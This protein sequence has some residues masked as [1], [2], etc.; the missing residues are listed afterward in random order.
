MIFSHPKR[1]DLGILRLHSELYHLLS[2]QTG[3]VFSDSFDA[4]HPTY[5]D[6]GQRDLS[7]DRRERTPSCSYDPVHGSQSSVSRPSENTELKPDKPILRRHSSESY[8]GLEISSPSQFP[9]SNQL[10]NDK[11]IDVQS[12]LPP[13]A[14]SIGLITHQSNKNPVTDLPREISDLIL[15]YLSPPALDAARFTCKPWHQ[16][17]TSNTWI[18]SQVL[19]MDPGS[20]LRD[21]LKALDI[22]SSLTHTFQHSDAWRPRFRK[23]KMDFSLSGSEFQYVS[24]T[25]LGSQYGLIAFQMIDQDIATS[26]QRKSTL[27]F[28]RFGSEDLARYAG[29]VEH[30]AVEGTAHISI[31]P[32]IQG[33]LHCCVDV[34]CDCSILRVDIGGTIA[35]YQI[36]DRKAFA[37]LESRYY[38]QALGSSD[39]ESLSKRLA[40]HAPEKIQSSHS[41]KCHSWTLLK[42]IPP[43]PVGSRLYFA[44]GIDMHSATRYVAEEVESG[45]IFV[46]I[47][48]FDKRLIAPFKHMALEPNERTTQVAAAV[49][50]R[51]QSKS[52]YINV[53]IA[54]AFTNHGTITLAIIWHTRHGGDSQ[55]ELYIYD[56][57]IS[58]YTHHPTADQPS[59][60]IQGKRI[61]S[62]P[63]LIGGIH[64]HSSLW[65]VACPR[66]AALGG[67]QLAQTADNQNTYPHN[68]QYRKCFLWG[69]TSSTQ[70]CT[71]ITC[72]IFDLS[73]ADPSRLRARKNGS[74]ARLKMISRGVK[75][76]ANLR[77]CACELHDTGFDITLPDLRKRYPSIHSPGTVERKSSF[78]P[79]KG[80]YANAEA[81]DIGIIVRNDPAARVEALKRREE[82]F[83]FRISEMKKRGLSDTEIAELWGLAVW[84]RWGQIRKPDG[85]QQL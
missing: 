63:P 84:T 21:L 31:I 18:L 43:A 3:S 10:G 82:W 60:M 22:D 61:S 70:E 81:Q 54:P 25:R 62:V 9:S 46:V 48:E 8:N 75:V 51:P 34:K 65:N 5:P 26:G 38:I 35:F 76:V 72:Q 42:H 24:C 67:L 23:S 68:I 7:K 19:G 55:S 27:L 56:I 33:T 79:W 47:D 85:W 36:Q 64:H 30:D 69:P 39:H 50:S 29:F 53:A 4:F 49:M 28:Y 37:S 45:N 66:L 77:D 57:P 78:W 12:D 41:T 59:R 74:D 1:E 17:I 20:S 71:K 32:H 44:E 16:A 40:L 80:I 6:Q 52:V 2:T 13:E 73:Y 11:H 58:V 15:S 83:R 14:Q